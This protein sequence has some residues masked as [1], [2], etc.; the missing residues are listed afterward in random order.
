MVPLSAET[1][2][3]LHAEFTGYVKGVISA[4]LAVG[5]AAATEWTPETR[6]EFSSRY[7]TALVALK[8]AVARS[9]SIALIR[10]SSTLARYARGAP[11]PPAAA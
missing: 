9:V 1:G 3:R 5:G 8:L 10:G 2:G 4:G 7:R 6:V 11:G